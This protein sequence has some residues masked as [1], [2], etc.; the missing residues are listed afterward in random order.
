MDHRVCLGI[1]PLAKTYSH[2]RLKGPACLATAGLH[3]LLDDFA[4]APLKT[5]SRRD[6]ETCD[7]RYQRHSMIP[8][9]LMSMAH[10]HEQ[11]GDSTPADSILDRL[12]HKLLLIERR[13]QTVSV[14]VLTCFA[15][16]WMRLHKSSGIARS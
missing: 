15:H 12:V 16:R 6:L 9:S 14:A 1:L 5:V 8:S 2:A 7:D 10:W 13:V 11:T 4:M 3:L